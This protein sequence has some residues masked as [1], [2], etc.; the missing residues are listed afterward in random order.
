MEVMRPEWRREE[1][2]VTVEEALAD[3]EISKKRNS[4]TETRNFKTQLLV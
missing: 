2:K 1:R 3:F 4:L